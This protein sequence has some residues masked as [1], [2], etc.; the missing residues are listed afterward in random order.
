MRTGAEVEEE[1]LFSYLSL[2]LSILLKIFLISFLDS[3]NPF[4]LRILEGV[5]VFEPRLFADAY[6][7]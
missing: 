7:P 3:F 1:S 4:S 6:S 2:F 5:K